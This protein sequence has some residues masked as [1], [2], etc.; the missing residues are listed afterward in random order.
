MRSISTCFVEEGRVHTV[1]NSVSLSISPAC[2]GARL[3]L[4]DLALQMRQKNFPFI[5]TC[6][7][8]SLDIG[9]S[10][11]KAKNQGKMRIHSLYLQSQTWIP[12]SRASLLMCQFGTT[13]DGNNNRIHRSIAVTASIIS[14]GGERFDVAMKWMLYNICV[15]ARGKPASVNKMELCLFHFLETLPEVSSQYV[16]RGTE[17]TRRPLALRRHLLTVGCSQGSNG[18]AGSCNTPRQIFN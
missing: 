1:I 3:F 18:N 14:S 10:P 2:P 5:P 4:S 15:S 6:E 9:L 8:N 17:C 11:W 16:Q 13:C 12:S 7:A